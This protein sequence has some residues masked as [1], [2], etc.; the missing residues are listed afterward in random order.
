MDY[1]DEFYAQVD[2]DFSAWLEKQPDE[3]QDMSLLDQIDLYAK[4][5]E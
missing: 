1:L 5:T 2:R 3:V 4:A